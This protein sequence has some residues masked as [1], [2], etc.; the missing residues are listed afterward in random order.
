MCHCGCVL[1]VSSTYRACDLQSGVTVESLGKLIDYTEIFR[2]ITLSPRANV[3][4]NVTLDHTNRCEK[5]AARNMPGILSI[6]VYIYEYSSVLRL[7]II[8]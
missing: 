3:V 7:L 6:S 5:L 4:K 2:G 1:Q 8:P